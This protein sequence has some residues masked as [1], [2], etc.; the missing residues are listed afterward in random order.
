M[1]NHEK[2]DIIGSKIL[3]LKGERNSKENS[4]YS[5]RNAASPFTV[6]VDLVSSSIVGLC[7]GFY[8]DRF[9]NL[10][11]ICLIICLLLGMIAGVKII[12][13]KLNNT[14]NK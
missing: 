9:F 1:E 12:F 4:D 2:F 10:K 8:L 7:V 3:A 14:T 11:P 6:T 5:Q 13:Q